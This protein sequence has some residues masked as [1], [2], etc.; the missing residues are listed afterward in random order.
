MV[1]PEHIPGMSH[2]VKVVSENVVG[3]VH[4]LFRQTLPLHDTV[5]PEHIARG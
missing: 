5:F 4:P 1:G 2:Y 3:R